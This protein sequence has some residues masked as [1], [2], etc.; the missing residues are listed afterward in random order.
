MDNPI[1]SELI[2]QS[3]QLEKVA[4]QIQKDKSLGLIHEQ[5]DQL[6]E[7]YQLWFAECLAVLPDDLKDDIRSE[8]KGAW[9]S[10]KIKHFL[11]GP[12]Q[13]NLLYSNQAEDNEINRYWS[14]PYEKTF[15][16]PLIAQRRIL[17]EA[18][19]RQPN[20]VSSFDAITSIERVTTRFP[21][22]VRQLNLRHDN[23]NTIK[24]QDEYDVQDLF[25]ALLRLIFDDIRPEETTHSY[26][27]RSSRV[28]FLLK[29]RQIVVEVKKTRPN[30]KAREVGEQLIIDTARYR[31]HP[32]CK[33]LIAFVYDP[34]MFIENPRGLENDLSGVKD[35]T[36]SKSYCCS[37]V[38]YPSPIMVTH[39]A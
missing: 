20:T 39:H 28:D 9:H 25:H 29:S 32:D 14:N 10:P 1:F 3:K 34:D 36:T 5:V 27:G 7:Q 4:S 23:R 2:N 31:S 15:R 38:K 33:L 6:V 26:A 35:W 37:R 11:E 8:Y 16:A 22:V 13:K 19:K 21:I 24:I 17:L 12:A 30:L 18:A